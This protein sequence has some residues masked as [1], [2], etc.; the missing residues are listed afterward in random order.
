MTSKID[1]TLAKSLIKEFQQENK[2]SAEHA[3]KTPDG[4]HLN[5][6]FIDRESLETILNDQKNVGIHLFIAKHPDFTGKPDRA[7]TLVFT[8]S[9][10]NTEPDAKTPYVSSGIVYH[11][12]PICPPFCTDL[13]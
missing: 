11:D 8:G 12:T 9:E 13:V 4:Q 6:F 1:P 7:H 5:G 3:L 2:A 10:P